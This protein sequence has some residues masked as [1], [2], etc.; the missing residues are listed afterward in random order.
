MENI[1]LSI[2]SVVIVLLWIWKLLVVM[3]RRGS[4][5]C[6][7]SCTYRMSFHLRKFYY[8]NGFEI[9]IEVERSRFSVTRGI[10]VFEAPMCAYDKHGLELPFETTENLGEFHAICVSVCVY[11]C[12]YIHNG[13]SRTRSPEESLASTARSCQMSHRGITL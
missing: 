9:R 4:R 5:T 3:D 2:I 10:Y 7:L 13:A 6:V 1:L 8:F 12:I 11:V